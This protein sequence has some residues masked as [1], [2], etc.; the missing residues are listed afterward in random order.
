MV[1]GAIKMTNNITREEA[2]KKVVMQNTSKGPV[3]VVSLDPRL[4]PFDAIQQ[5]NYRAMTSL[6]PYL[7]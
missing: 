1:D 7:I 5:K 3:M 4:P 6:D 2:L